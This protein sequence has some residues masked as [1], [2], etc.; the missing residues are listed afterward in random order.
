MYFVKFHFIDMDNHS[1]D[2]NYQIQDAEKEL[3]HLN[4][5]II[6][7][8]ILF[9]ELENFKNFYEMLQNSRVLYLCMCT[10]IL[11]RQQHGNLFKSSAVF[12]T[13]TQYHK[14]KTVALL[15]A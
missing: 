13:L 2:R 11:T 14:S 8:F 5:I 7:E 4:G 12:T 15:Q 6:K 10:C 3:I 1:L 9:S